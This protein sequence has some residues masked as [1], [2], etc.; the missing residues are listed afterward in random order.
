MRTITETRHFEEEDLTEEVLICQKTGEGKA[1]LYEKIFTIVY[2]YPQRW[3][4]IQEED[5]SKFLITFAPLVSSMVQR[6]TYTG[7]P[8]INYLTNCIRNRIRTFKH[9]RYEEIAKDIVTT[10][11]LY[12]RIL[13]TD[14]Y[15]C[16]CSES[17]LMF[18]CE[19]TSETS[20]RGMY[21]NNPQQLLFMLL[22]CCCEIPQQYIPVCNSYFAPLGYDFESSY[23][24]LMGLCEKKHLRLEHLKERRNYCFTR[25]ISCD[26]RIRHSDDPVLS[27]EL[28]HERDEI[29]RQFNLLLREI[30]DFQIHPSHRM[31]AEVL[32]IPKGTVDSG[33]FYFK[34]KYTQL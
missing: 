14:S 16:F 9:Q 4:L 26:T 19:G 12:D 27:R 33:I 31:I 20:K 30:H 21:Q 28:R 2:E 7:T 1:L 6:F 8:F 32:D 24:R 15:T 23:R 5:A 17:E 25:M 34:K 22:Y 3:R 11:N 29:E 10:N 18:S 13:Q